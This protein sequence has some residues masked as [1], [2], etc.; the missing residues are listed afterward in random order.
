MF[1][2]RFQLILKGAAMGMAEVIPG[3][4]GGT[5]AFITGIY[6][7]LLESIKA[8]GPALIPAWKE[9]GIKGVW[10]KI[11]GNF[12]FFL[13]TGM[14]TGLIVGVFLI[15]WLLE[16]YPPVVWAFFFGLIIASAIYIARQVPCW[17]WSGILLLVVGAAFAYWITIVSP[18]SGSEAWW[19]IFVSGM[20]AISALILPGISG[21][22]I[23]LLL[24]MYTFIVPTVKEA[25]KTLDP[26]SLA[27]MGVFGLGCLLGLAIFSRVL[28]WLF[29]HYRSQTLAL[30]TGFMLGSLNRLWPWQNVL[31]TRI[32]SSGEEVP[33]ET[34][35]VLP[36]A[37]VEGDPMVLGVI[38]A[39]IGGFAI[40]FLLDRMGKP[41]S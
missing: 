38:L 3:V 25:L 27:V 28:S 13:L 37:F 8:F 36:G 34:Q 19:F 10:N 12:L 4:S 1:K 39:A 15:S 9:A 40:V 17:N 29:S 31:T 33:L 6:E 21:S 14:A 20:I 5:I 7:K 26:Q 11:N 18:T 30:L 23:L 41:A 22:F 32:N 35:N 16:N 24:G 2:D